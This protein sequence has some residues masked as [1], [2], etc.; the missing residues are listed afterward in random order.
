MD[1]QVELTVTIA[2]KPE[3]VPVPLAQA[4]AAELVLEGVVGPVVTS[5]VDF[6]VTI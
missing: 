5:H 1:D 3:E 6:E 2:S 4:V